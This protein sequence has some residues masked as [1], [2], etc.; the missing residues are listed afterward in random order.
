[1]ATPILFIG[2]G[3]SGL[4]ILE[5]TQRF[6][7]ST[8][9]KNRPDHVRYLFLETHREVKRDRTP[10]GTDI[11]PLFTPISN[12]GAMVQELNQSALEIDKEWLPDPAL[13]QY[14]DVGAGGMRC[15]G[16][17][18]LWSLPSGGGDRYF[19]QLHNQIQTAIR[20]L[21]H[22]SKKVAVHIVGS[23][24][25]GTASGMFLDAG[26]LTRFI[27][28]PVGNATPDVYG[29]FL[30][31]PSASNHTR[32]LANS[33]GCIKDLDRHCQVES[34]FDARWPVN[35]RPHEGFPQGTSPFTLTT[36]L[37]MQ[38]ATGEFASIDHLYKISGLYCFATALGFHD[39]RGARLI[40]ALGAPKD[41]RFGK[42]S[43]FNLSALIF[44]RLEIEECLAAEKAQQLLGG[45]VDEDVCHGHAIAGAIDDQINRRDDQYRKR[46]DRIIENAFAELSLA[47][48][49]NN[50]EVDLRSSLKEFLSGNTGKSLEDNYR[51]LFNSNGKIYRYIVDRAG[52][53]L[54][55][56]VEGIEEIFR[57][58]LDQS[59]SLPYARRVLEV[60]QSYLT[61]VLEHWDSHKV[62]QWDNRLT[63]LIDQ[64]LERQ[65]RLLGERRTILLDR[66]K[67][68]VDLMKMHAMYANVHAV[69]KHIESG[70]EQHLRKSGLPHK[71]W[72]SGVMETIKNVISRDDG[73]GAPAEFESLAH[74]IKILKNRGD[75]P[76][77]LLEYFPNGDFESEVEKARAEFFASAP[78]GT[79]MS[80][81][82]LGYDES[83]WNYL[84]IDSDQ[85]HFR[86][87][88]D[89]LSGFWD[90]IHDENAVKDLDVQQF[91]REQPTQLTDLA[92]SA[93]AES[94]PLKRQVRNAQQEHP[95][96]II[97]GNR[98]IQQEALDALKAR[99]FI[100]FNDAMQKDGSTADELTNMII[101]FDERGAFNPMEDLVNIEAWEKYYQ[102]E[103]ESRG[104]VDA[105][106]TDS[107]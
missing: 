31:P 66:M 104:A 97:T 5:H 56:L 3:T 16:R 33:Y 80:R 37:S 17:L 35:N 87:L 64:M 9:G 90:R 46:V 63:S 29:L 38:W 103:R 70:A 101:F 60:V 89:S 50:I 7:Y 12:A 20:E 100:D 105:Y 59:D 68:I 79:S 30:L 47:G 10:A 51:E 54:G 75:R 67:A 65:R 98:Q 73:K 82:I 14:V 88:E 18:A 69:N 26:Y 93:T 57:E 19:T 107:V 32:L 8:T 23:F 4:R 62:Q 81:M 36:F 85:L 1:M 11:K 72:I 84:T 15:F 78:E 55:I 102:Q 91:I 42:Y 95:K 52:H 92:R 61:E 45:M 76:P 86:L 94:I 48:P 99:D 28:D 49:N 13:M 27:Q 39:Y 24:A 71:T 83:L 25:G 43:F 96:V 106:E 44:P 77:Q 40:D 74:R 34:K 41:E 21:S 58:A 6:F 22:G 2:L 53:G